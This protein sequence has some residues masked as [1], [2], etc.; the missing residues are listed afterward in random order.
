MPTKTRCP[1]LISSFLPHKHLAMACEH[2]K[3][4]GRSQS[5][6]RVTL[7][8]LVATIF[9]CWSLFFFCMFIK[10]YSTTE[11]LTHHSGTHPQDGEDDFLISVQVQ[12]ELRKWWLDNPEKPVGLSCEQPRRMRRSNS[13]L[14]QFSEV[15]KGL[16]A[17]RE[18]VVPKGRRTKL[19]YVIPF[20]DSQLPK[21]LRMLQEWIAYPPCHRHRADGS[22]TGVGAS[23]PSS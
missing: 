14:H 16:F 20:V 21:F 1:R 10:R 12:A 22:L 7:G 3:K 15:P 9:L 19:A 6:F 17:P 23:S 11:G 18:P 8:C 4:R 2:R 13:V 5:R